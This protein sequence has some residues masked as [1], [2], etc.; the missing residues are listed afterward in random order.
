[1]L[2]QQ[3]SNCDRFGVGCSRVYWEVDDLRIMVKADLK[4]CSYSIESGCVDDNG[5]WEGQP[6]ALNLS[7]GISLEYVVDMFWIHLKTF[8]GGEASLSIALDALR[9]MVACQDAGVVKYL[10]ARCGQLE[11]HGYAILGRWRP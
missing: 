3:L 9:H 6:V 7:G 11:E 10:E 1:M 5:V 2:S 8:V 4:R